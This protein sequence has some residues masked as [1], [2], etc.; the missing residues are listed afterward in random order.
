MLAQD[1]PKMASGL[2]NHSLDGPML[3]SD[4][5][6]LA[7]DGHMLAQGGAQD[8]SWVAQSWAK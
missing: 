5:P 8:G 1:G 6:T 3:R 4:G 2:S 7:Q